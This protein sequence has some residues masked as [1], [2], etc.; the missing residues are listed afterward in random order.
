MGHRDQLLRYKAAPSLY[1][2][3][4]ECSNE[5]NHI[6]PRNTLRTFCARCLSTKTEDNEQQKNI[7][8]LTYTSH[9]LEQEIFTSLG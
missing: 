9:T 1:K 8:T 4:V 6:Y 5:R 2:H 7:V 3:F